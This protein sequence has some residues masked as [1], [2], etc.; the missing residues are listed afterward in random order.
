LFREV[1][2]VVTNPMRQIA[3]FFVWHFGMAYSALAA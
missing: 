1:I 3:E 2:L